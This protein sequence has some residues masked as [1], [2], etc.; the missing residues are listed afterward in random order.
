MP[1]RFVR[2]RRLAL[3]VGLAVSSLG[4]TACSLAGDNTLPPFTN[5]ATQTYATVTGVNIANMTRVS[6]HLYTEDVVVGTGKEVAVGDSITV[7]YTGRLNSGFQFDARNAP[8]TPF[9]TV[10]D[11]T[12]LIR[13]WVG[14]LPG[15]RVGGTRRMVIGPALAY[16]Y[17][18]VRDNN[19]S[20]IIPANSVLVFDVQVVDAR[21]R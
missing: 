18:T 1:S 9:A 11:S 14:G 21:V 13:G 17:S 19:G 7:Y 2:S 8:A 3:F 12:R 5:P 20:I 15:A 4:A 16:Q 10:L 6:Q